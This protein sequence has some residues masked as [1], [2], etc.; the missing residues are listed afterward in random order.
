MAIGDSIPLSWIQFPNLVT[1]EPKLRYV[2]VES[3][4]INLVDAYS[5]DSELR[6]Y[7][8]KVLQD[9][10]HL[11]PPY[12]GAPLLRKET[13]EQ[14]PEIVEA[15]NQLA[16]T[17]TDDEM[18][19]MNYKVNVEGETILPKLQRITCK[20]RDSFNN[21]RLKHGDG[22]GSSS[23]ISNY[24]EMGYIGGNKRTVRDH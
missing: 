1:M 10:Q 17:V 24:N 13:V 23:I 20:K 7:N 11:F 8:L 9:D 19:E 6:Q 22:S 21:K 3:G 15:L 2:A 4:E 18:R 14:Y 12:Q 5:T 16:G